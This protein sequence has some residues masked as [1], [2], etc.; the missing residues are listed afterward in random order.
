MNYRTFYAAVVALL[1][2][3]Q[4]FGGDFAS[5]I[6]Q[7]TFKFQNPG[8][9]ATCFLMRRDEPDKAMYLVT[10]GHVFESTKGETAML[11]LRE[12]QTDGTYIRRE[13][14]V[15]IR[16]GETPLWTRHSKEDVAA[17]RLAEPL[18]VAVRPLPLS[19]LADEERL[20]AE[21]LHTCSPIFVLTY[22]RQFEANDWG[23][24]VTRQG[25]I[26]SHPF[27]PTQPNHRYL[28]DF[29]TFP[30]DSGAPVFVT[31]KDGHPLIIGINIAEFRHDEKVSMEYQEL[32]IQHPF[33][34]GIVL[35]PQ[36]IRETIENASQQHTRTVEMERAKSEQ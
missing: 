31:T 22:P 7:A 21:G 13:H 23:F 36:I 11:V 15:S 12:L 17:L 19:D 9:T 20:L 29:T 35:Y 27:L 3:M 8:C 26:S 16:L 28:A 14:K 2:V 18:P 25:I 33:G 5:E 6:I 1:T 4:V 24:P 10:A 32:T 30:G 34:L